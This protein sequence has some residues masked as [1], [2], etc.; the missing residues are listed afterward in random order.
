[1]N[2]FSKLLDL[3]QRELDRLSKIVVK[4]NEQDSKFKKLKDE[5]FKK[6]TSEF[7]ERLKKGEI[8][9]SILPEAFALVR[10]AS[11]RAIGLRPFD[12]QL[13]AAIALFEGKVAEQ[14]TGEGKTL[15]AVPALY[16]HALTG[17]SVHLVTVN[18]YLA[19]RDCG[20]MGPV[21]NFL[22]LTVSSIISEESF[23]FDPKHKNNNVHDFRLLRLRPVDR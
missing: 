7:K 2:I 14:K 23:V 9:E 15:S 17:K 5:D 10:E 18:D 6:K 19:R 1:M 3:N 12:V 22:G 20:W 11:W 8:L 13:M 16:L 4:I 21:F